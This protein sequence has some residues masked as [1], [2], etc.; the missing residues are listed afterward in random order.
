MRTAGSCT[1]WAAP[2]LLTALRLTSVAAVTGGADHHQLSGVSLS[3]TALP[4]DQHGLPITTGEASVLHAPDGYYYFYFND[5]GECYCSDNPS[6]GLPPCCTGAGKACVYGGNHTVIVYKTDL[7][8]RPLTPN[9]S[10]LLP[11]NPNCS[12]LLPLT[13]TYSQFAGIVIVVVGQLFLG[14]E[15]TRFAGVIIQDRMLYPVSNWQTRPIR[16]AVELLLFAGTVW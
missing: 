8:V 2:M 16:S 6:L 11:L 7:K 10:H 1:A 4:L 13:P 12:H 5:W 14:L 15:S 3:N 9:C